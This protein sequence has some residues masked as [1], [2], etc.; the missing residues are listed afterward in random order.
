MAPAEGDLPIS[1]TTESNLD[2]TA[3]SYDGASTTLCCHNHVPLADW[4]ASDGYILLLRLAIYK[5]LMAIRVVHTKL[6]QLRRD[7]DKIGMF[8]F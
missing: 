7:Q 1:G 2:P 8:R 4:R 5:K 3:E 6:L